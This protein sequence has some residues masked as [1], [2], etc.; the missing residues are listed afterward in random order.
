MKNRFFLSFL[1]FLC[2]FLLSQ[3]SAS[4]SVLTVKADFAGTA[5]VMGNIKTDADPKCKLM[6]P[7]GLQSDEVLVNPNST[8]KNVFVYVK[9]GLEGKKFESPKTPVVFDQV[10]CHYTPKVVGIM[11]PS[12]TF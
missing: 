2:A 1:T 5:P 11:V 4:A 10:G 7:D 3:A 6:H 8:L 9:A 12:C